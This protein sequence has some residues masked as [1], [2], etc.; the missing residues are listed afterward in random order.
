MNKRVT[1]NVGGIRHEVMWR[2][3][4]Q[5]PESRLGLL[6]KVFSST[7]SD[8]KSKIIFRQTAMMTFSSIALDIL[9][10]KTNFILI[11]LSALNII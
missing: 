5:I 2:M 10:L 7:D 6:S 11:G 3:L 1:L 9:L 4:E 8:D